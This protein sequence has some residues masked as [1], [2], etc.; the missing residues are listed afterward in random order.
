MTADDVIKIIAALGVGSGIS[1]ISTAVIASRSQKGKARAE[2]ADLWI[3]TAE[4]MGKLNSEL[5]EEVRGLKL[6]VDVMQL[7]MFDYLGG[8]ISREELLER[9]KESRK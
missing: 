9:I 1:A 3:G 4:R 5:D 6:T 8:V 2:A 7:A